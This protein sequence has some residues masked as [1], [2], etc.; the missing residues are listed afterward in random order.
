MVTLGSSLPDFSL[1]DQ[2]DRP[3]S[4]T[5]LLGSTYV[6]IFY[7]GD[8]TPGCT[9]QLCGIRDEWQ[10]F[11]DANIKVF[12]VNHGSKTSHK[13]FE[14]TFRLPFPLLVDEQKQFS[15]SVGAVKKLFGLTLIKRVVIGIDK[16]GIVRMIKPGMPKVADIIKAMKPF[17][18]T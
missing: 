6:L 15:E 11:E 1:H 18:K 17:A 8:L 16:E 2:I 7:P 5:S 3:I 12:G 10:T 14:T 9:L 13:R 4:K